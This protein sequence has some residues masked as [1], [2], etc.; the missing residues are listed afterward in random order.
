MDLRKMRILSN[1]NVGIGTQNPDKALYI[2]GDLKV[3]GNISS[4]G[5]FTVVNTDTT[6]TDQVNVTNTGTNTAIIVNQ[7]GSQLIADFQDDGTSVFKLFDGGRLGLGNMTGI[8]SINEVLEVNGALKVGNASGTGNGTIKYDSGDFM[9]RKAGN[10]VSLTAPTKIESN[11]SNVEVSDSGSNGYIS[12]KTDN[13]ERMRV[14]SD[15]DISVTAHIIPTVDS[16]YDL[17]SGTYKFRDIYVSENSIWVGEFQLGVNEQ[18]DTRKA[19]FRQRKKD[20]DGKFKVPRS[21]QKYV[22]SSGA[23]PG[24]ILFNGVNYDPGTMPIHLLNE[25]MRIM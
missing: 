18:G 20:N 4:T 2:V 6:S 17:G 13:T 3:E 8:N 7:T 15:G 23:E 5:N 22:G 10:W 9:G 25:F 12:F 24:K 14:K 11:D 21:I 1:G 16:T 19:G